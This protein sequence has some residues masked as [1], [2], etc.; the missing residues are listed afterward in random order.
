MV[1]I[2]VF[3]DSISYGAWDEMGGWVQRLRRW[4]DR[5]NIRRD[6]FYCLV[7][8][9]SVS[10][11]TVGDVIERFEPEVDARTKEDDDMVFIFQ[12]GT[13]DAQLL[14]GDCVVRTPLDEFR[15]SVETLVNLAKKH[16]HK[17]MFLGMMPADESRTSP[18]PWNKNL[19]YL[20]ENLKLY[21][22][23]LKDVCE[24]KGAVFVNVFD[25]LLARD[26][27]KMLHDGLHPNPAGHGFIFKEVRRALIKNRF[28]G[29]PDNEA[30]KL[31]RD[32]IPEILRGMGLNVKVRVLKDDDSY[33][34]A[35]MNKL[36]EEVEEFF[37]SQNAEELVDIL[38]VV[39]ALASAQGVDRKE[40]EE[41]RRAKVEERGG[42]SKRFFLEDAE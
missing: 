30:G 17:I 11:N 3:G 32:A 15:K 18:V 23:A 2:L 10:G 37:E 7:Y 26:Y 22:Q 34:S 27:K 28:V 31:V 40:L 14:I 13:N 36:E 42:F 12:V 25:T 39:Y 38:E 16:S 29:I 5:I 20:N 21:N 35:L 4:I 33:M 24:K 19:A 8:N 41:L 9:L 6:D 1:S